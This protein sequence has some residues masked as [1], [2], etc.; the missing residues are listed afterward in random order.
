[1][2]VSSGPLAA[3]ARRVR[4]ALTAVPSLVAYVVIRVLM[5]IA[6]SPVG[7]PPARPHRPHPHSRATIAWFRRM[8]QGSPL[9]A[10]LQARGNRCVYLPTCTEYA[11]RAVERYGLVRGLQ[12]T[13]D[14]FRRCSEGGTGSY[15]DF[16]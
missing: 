3:P 6:P 8:Y 2:A 9:R 16:P 13:G 4:E 1:M 12:L 5:R 11:E 15:V 7:P 14:R 10:Q